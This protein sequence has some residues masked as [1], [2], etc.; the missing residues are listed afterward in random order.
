MNPPLSTLV[1]APESPM[2]MAGWRELWAA[3]DL[4]R[5]LVWRDLKTRYSQSVLGLGWAVVQP[6][7]TMGVFTVIFG[8]LVGVK[9][10]S[11]VPY[12]VFSLTA[13]V[14]WTF[15]QSI[16]NDAS[17]CLTTNMGLVT[18]VYFPR[19]VLPL[20]AVTVRLFD[21]VIMLVL[22]A[23]TLAVARLKPEA[24][25]VAAV[26]VALL[27]TLVLGTGAG[28]WLSALAVQ[29]RDVRHGQMFLLQLL[30]YASPVIYAADRVPKAWQRLYSL[31]PLVGI[32][33]AMRGSLLGM[34]PVPWGLLGLDTVL[35][36]ILYAS[37]AWYFHRAM[38]LFAD[39]A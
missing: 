12:A 2:G 9:T 5:F 10:G 28:L 23:A 17:G 29:Y 22:L 11:A 16:V 4:W 27:I 35:A 30:M 24:S 31:N 3:R 39:V 15:F 20:A 13:V 18:K 6:L 37:G 33:G 21:L 25:A 36:I 26:P 38:R 8:G 7:F 32:I 14:V 1:I 34:G 19:M